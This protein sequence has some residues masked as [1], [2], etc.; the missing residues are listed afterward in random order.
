MINF[1][2]D[3]GLLPKR[4]Q[5]ISWTNVDISSLRY[6][7]IQLRAI[8]WEMLHEL[9]IKMWH[10]TLQPHL[11]GANE[12]IRFTWYQ[13]LIVPGN[14]NNNSHRKNHPTATGKTLI[15]PAN[16]LYIIMFKSGKSSQIQA[17]SGKSPKV[18]TVTVIIWH[19]VIDLLSNN[20][21][22]KIM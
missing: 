21:V 9:I 16:L 14:D 3:N 19:V 22:K 11:S 1:G 18:F 6:H 2:M 12:L 7:D 13:E 8:S 15:R 17:H 5:A 4:H 10:L 20:Q